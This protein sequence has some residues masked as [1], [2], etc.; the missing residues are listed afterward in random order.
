MRN[1]VQQPRCVW[2]EKNELGKAL[3]DCN[4]AIRLD[5]TDAMAF[6]NRGDVWYIKVD[7]DKA[8]ADY[9]E[10]IRLDP[11]NAMALQRPGCCLVR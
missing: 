7:Y 3:A 10:A 2:Y 5:R 4:E 6:G 8:L 1:G 9:N 11:K